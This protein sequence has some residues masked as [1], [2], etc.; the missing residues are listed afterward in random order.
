MISITRSPV[1]LFTNSSCLFVISLYLVIIILYG[2]NFYVNIHTIYI[3]AYTIFVFFFVNISNYV[4]KGHGYQNTFSVARGF[5]CRAPRPNHELGFFIKN[6]MLFK[7]P[8]H[9]YKKLKGFNL[10]TNVLYTEYCLSKGRQR[11]PLYSQYGTFVGCLL[12]V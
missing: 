1:H 4:V 2:L 7:R 3:A 12:Y 11:V 6:H 8:K 10:L 9:N 5:Y